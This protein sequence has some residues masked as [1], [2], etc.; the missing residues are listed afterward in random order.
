VDPDDTLDVAERSRRVVALVAYLV[1]SGQPHLEPE[2]T[3]RDSYPNLPV[4]LSEAGSYGANSRKITSYRQTEGTVVIRNE[5]RYAARNPGVRI[6]LH[7]LLG[8]KPPD[9]WDVVSWATTVGPTAIQWDGG[10]NYIIHGKWHRTLPMIDFD[11]VVAYRQRRPELIVSLVA[12]GSPPR[13]WRIPV[14]LLD[15]DEYKSYSALREKD[16]TGEC[17]TSS[18]LGRL[19]P[20]KWRRAKHND[21]AGM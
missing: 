8:L 20:G 19:I 4:F 14:Q 7:G 13:R 11:E 21:L 1:A 3:F 16:L 17:P 10:A 15:Q 12:D 2:I 18:G 9:G 5:S 6:E